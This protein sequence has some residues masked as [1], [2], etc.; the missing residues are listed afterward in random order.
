[1]SDAAKKTWLDRF[2]KLHATPAWEETLKSQG[3]EDAYL[4]GDAFNAFL[5]EENANWTS[6]LKEVG[7]LK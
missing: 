7:I 6:A 1:M 4:P 2:A 3:W 5:K